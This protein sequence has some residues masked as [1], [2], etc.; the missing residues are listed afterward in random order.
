MSNVRRFMPALALALGAYLGLCGRAFA[1]GLQ[2][3]PPAPHSEPNKNGKGGVE[4]PELTGPYQVGRTSRHLVDASRK[5]VFTAAPDEVRELMVTVHYPAEA[6]SVHS[7]ALYADV[8]VASAISATYHR[9]ALFFEVMHSHAMDKA[10][11]VRKDKG[12]PVVIFSPGFTVHPLFY[13]AMLEDLAS[14]GFVVVSVCHPYSTGVTVFPDGRTLRANDAG[15]RFELDK[16][17]PG[18]SPK[19][20]IKHRD[21]IGEVWVADVRFALDSLAHFNTNDVLLEG[22]LDLSHVGIFGH[23]FGGATAAAAVQRDKRFRAGINLDGSDFSTTN[24]EVIRESFLWLCSERPNFA[25]VTAP[26]LSQVRQGNKA[27]GSEPLPR[28]RG[29]VY[30]GL[31][32]PPGCRITISGARHQTFASDL[33][34]AKATPFSRL[35]ISEG[36]GTIDGRRA[37]YITNALVSGFFRKHLRGENVPFLDTPSSKFP[38]AI[39]ESAVVGNAPRAP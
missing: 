27:D 3:D 9:P 34:L 12:L 5:E 37:V 22:R 30:D 29:Q 11:C 15:T 8:K 18:I 10:P 21:A 38:E 36:M 20:M 26:R 33:A 16:K 4:F 14:Q 13:T 32:A 25:K 24:G 1:Q 6:P 23:S 19:T 17:K 35:V 7:T 28:P 2:E 31:R 39:R